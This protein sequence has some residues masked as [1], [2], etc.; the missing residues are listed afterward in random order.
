MWRFPPLRLRRTPRSRQLRNLLSPLR[1]HHDPDPSDPSSPFSFVCVHEG[2]ATKS[3]HRPMI[4]LAGPMH[5][6]LPLALPLLFVSP[7]RVWGPSLLPTY[8]VRIMAIRQAVTLCVPSSLA[9]AH[10]TPFLRSNAPRH[11][12]L[13]NHLQRVT[14][15]CH[16]QFTHCSNCKRKL[17]S[18]IR[19]D[20]AEFIPPANELPG[21]TEDESKM[22]DKELFDFACRCRYRHRNLHIVAD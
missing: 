9:L 5:H 11:R 17:V 12:G 16:P 1:L 18:A 10:V 3:V 14:H 20:L 4:N 19:R 15:L 2:I 7:W 6:L 21:T 22:T 8:G 13:P